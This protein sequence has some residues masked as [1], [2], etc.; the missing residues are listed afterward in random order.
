MSNRGTRL[1][2]TGH[3]AGAGTAGGMR[4][5]LGCWTASPHGMFADVMIQ[6]PDG[7]RILLAPDQWVAEFVSATYTFDEVQ[8]VPVSIQRSDAG[9]AAGSRWHVTAGPLDWYF[10]V[11]RRH[12]LGH[13]LRAVPGP[14]GTSLTMARITDRVAGVV[15]PG[16]RTLGTAGNDRTEWY[17]ARD[18]H[19]LA[20]SR[21]TWDGEDLGALADLDPPADFGFSSTPRFPSLTTL[22]STVRIRPEA[23]G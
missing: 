14:V 19:R 13:L 11:G 23:S 16:V 2:F 1:R 10:E 4:L 15:M 7:H 8:Q 17:A 22:T 6:R 12:A 5:V 21:A 3:I 18:L 9:A 20:A